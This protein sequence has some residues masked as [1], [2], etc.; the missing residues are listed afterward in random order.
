MK[1]MMERQQRKERNG[2]SHLANPPIHIAILS[3]KVI[4][5][6]QKLSGTKVDCGNMGQ[7]SIRRTV[8]GMPESSSSAVDG[9]GTF[10]TSLL[11]TNCDS[12]S[13]YETNC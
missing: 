9:F 8:N 2:R 11:I 12:C 3:W 1:F 5:T 7:R 6:V 10:P 13:Y 4:E